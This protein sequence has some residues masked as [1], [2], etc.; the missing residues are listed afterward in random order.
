MTDFKVGDR[1]VYTGSSSCK[2]IKGNEYNVS[3]LSS[4]HGRTLK[5]HGCDAWVNRIKFKHAQKKNMREESLMFKVG[6]KL[7]RVGPES[8]DGKI[9]TGDINEVTSMKGN[10]PCFFGGNYSYGSFHFELVKEQIKVGDKVRARENY[11][12]IVKGEIY[13]VS[14]EN[15]YFIRL[16]EKKSYSS[17]SKS[18]FELVKDEIKVGDLVKN[19]G[20]TYSNFSI[21]D[22]AEVVDITFCD[23]KNY[24]VFKGHDCITHVYNPEH[25]EKTQIEAGDTVK[26]LKGSTTIFC[27]MANYKAEKVLDKVLFIKSFAFD[28]SKFRLI[29]KGDNKNNQMKEDKMNANIT[30]EGIKNTKQQEH[31]QKKYT[32][33]L[34]IKDGESQVKIHCFSGT[35]EEAFKR[36]GN[37]DGFQATVEKLRVIAEQITGKDP[38]EGFTK[39]YYKEPVKPA[40]GVFKWFTNDDGDDVYVKLVMENNGRLFL[41]VCDYSGKSIS[42]GSLMMMNNDGAISKP[43]HVNKN[44]GIKLNKKGQ[45]KTK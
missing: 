18:R 20:G 13:T 35:F 41:K 17:W 3:K 10:N 5:V 24:L 9:K 25:F 38:M 11:K 39:P 27:E 34:T 42:G 8:S 37:R 32:G 15:K 45:V 33:E 2:L 44:I 26:F 16:K 22:V 21:G 30:I 14:Y 31:C 29:K 40:E 36:A 12:G 6:D 4:S 23:N 28:K 43:T 7:K 1:V 19:I